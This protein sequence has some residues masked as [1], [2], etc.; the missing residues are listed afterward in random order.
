MSQVDALRM[1]DHVR[2]RLV[3]LAVSE[4]YF[5]DAQ[6]SEVAR[7]LWS[8]PGTEGGLVSELWVEGAF[9]GQRSTDSLKSLNKEGLLP[10]GLY[11]QIAK[12]RVFPV[13]RELYTH[14]LEAFRTAGTS[15]KI[16]PSIVITAGTGLGKTEAF[17]L[18]MLTDLWRAGERLPDGGMRCLIIYPM[19]ALVA[20]QVERI[21]KWLNGQSQ[22]SVFHFTSETPEDARAANRRGE[23]FWANCRMRTR[24]EARGY[25]AHDGQAIE[26]EP[27]GA[28][29]DIVITNYSM[30]EYMLCR[31]QDSR[32][33]GPDLRC[34]IVDEAH[35]YSGVL[36]TEIMMLLRR[37]RERCGVSSEH[38]LHIATSATLGGD[39]ST[40]RTFA[41]DL[42]STSTKNTTVLRGRYAENDFASPESPPAQP[43][44]ASELG[45]FADLELRT[46][47]EEGEII[48]EGEKT[49]VNLSDI[50]S[51]LVSEDVADKS[52]ADFRNCPARFL[53][54]SLHQAPLIRKM[55]NILSDRK[56]NVLCLEEL[57]RLL[58]DGQCGIDERKAT[59]ALLRLSASARFR[60]TDLP[61]VPH[62][63]HFLVRA[64]EGAS[65]CLNSR[66][67]GP[68]DYRLSAIGCLQPYGDRCIYCQ[69]V[70][71]PVHR[72][73][74]CGDWALAAHE[75]Q[76]LCVLEPGYFAA[77]PAHR[78]YYLL[79]KP[80]E[81]ELQEVTIDSEKGE[82]L[83]YGSDGVT[84]W[85]APRET[86]DSPSQHCPTCRSSWAVPVADE[87]EPEWRHTCRG[88][89]G[90]RPFALSVTAE[91]VL[92]D[93]PPYRGDS[94]NWKPAKG[95]RL[96]CFSDSRAAAA[97]LGP[98][99]TQQHEVQVVRAAMAR[100][101]TD[102][103]PAD[104]AD[105]FAREVERL[106]SE[107][108]RNTLTPALRDQLQNELMEKRE[109]LERSKAGTPF[110]QFA[111]LVA[112]R[113]EM[114]ELLERR[115]AEK[116]TASSFG[117][118][119][120]RRNRDAVRM[121]AEAL[122]AKELCR[123]LK[124]Q[125][126][127]E[128]VGLVE[129]AY[130]GIHAL[131]LP[132]LF[133]EKLTPHLRTILRRNWA[134]IVTLL[135]DTVR[136]DGCIDWS[137][138][139][140]GRTWLDESPLH[141]RWLT[142][143][144]GGWASR[145]FVGATISQLRRAFLRNV[146]LSVGSAQA[147]AE[148]LSESALEAIFDQLYA[149]AGNPQFSWLRREEYHQIGP[150][151]ADK[152]I[153][154]LFD[155]LTVRVPTR[156]FRCDATGTIWTNSAV[157]WA[158]IEG[159]RGTLQG[160]DKE[161]LD[162]DPRWGRP[163]RELIDSPILSMGLWAEEHS[164]QLSPQENRRLQDLFKT[165]IRN[166]LSSTTTMELG[167]D[168]GG[169][170]GVLL[171]NVPPG[172]ANHRQRAGRAG[173]RSD[174]TAVVATFARDSD[175]DR[176]AFLRFGDFL[177]RELRKPKVFLNRS[178]V[179]RRHLH[180]VLL[181]EFLR[182]RQ[183]AATGA[184]HAFGKMGAFC[185]INSIPPRWT[186]QSEP[187]PSW[188]CNG[189]DTADEFAEWLN[190]IKSED[191]G[192]RGRLHELSIMTG[193]GNLESQKEWLEF[194]RQ[195]K[196]GFVKGVDEWKRNI[197]QLR[198]AWNE[199]PP[200]PRSS[201]LREMAKA[202]SVR[203]MISA[204]CDIT[205]IEWLADHRFLPR[206]GFPI[207]LQSLSIRRPAGETRGDHSRTDERYRLER[208]SLLALR[209][210][211]PES[212]VLV[213]GRVATSRG[214]RKHWTDSNLDQ[215]LGL[216]YSALECANEHVYVRQTA[217]EACPTCKGKP[218]AKQSLVFPRF[219][220]TTAGWDDL[221]LGTN[222]ER[223]GEQVVCPISF[224]ER[225][226]GGILDDF[227]QI[228]GLRVSYREEAELLVRNSGRNRCGFAICTRCGFAMSEAE[229]GEG[230]MKLPSTFETHAP[231]FSS[232]ERSFCWSK[233]EQIAPVL[234]NR[235]LAARELTDMLLIEWPA[236]T[237]YEHDS[238][239]SL[240]RALALAGTRL[241]ELDERELG[242]E[243]LPLQDS[244]LGIVI[245]ETSPGGSGHCQELIGLGREWIEVSRDVLYVDTA[246]DARCTKACL[247]CILDFSGQYAARRLN[248]PGALNLLD[249]AVP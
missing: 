215:A 61:L 78:T 154:I 175:Y 112:F 16:R 245:Y 164:A 244:N 240:G 19:N 210:Y 10:D 242:M 236:A 22:L 190:Q 140:E 235:V 195:A 205:V 55:A 211:V 149:S 6:I 131:E 30:L 212:Q 150:E 71:L 83:G 44:A 206:Y 159:C 160:I 132:P 117:Q 227:G 234:R 108:S 218:V 100:C 43:A 133:E 52:R 173:R 194:V 157:G 241:L 207:N 229:H 228:P 97:R 58:F 101:V 231:I 167:I 62:R 27:F 136:A 14:Q 156:L 123:P 192:V 163:R 18:P 82:I 40:L 1:A 128:S 111:R 13:E 95:R 87:Q 102:L 233:G 31:P 182:S 28:P 77:S 39:D 15:Q 120:W 24:Q 197:N 153:Q 54:S 225:G 125:T 36:A 222:L 86:R 99:L 138:D 203:Y 186:R 91:T 224:A 146:F 179:I 23:P 114:T 34:I 57:S 239:Y 148:Q 42:F 53:R 180:A 198:D 74:N 162:G 208:S 109:Q 75:N 134:A 41:S 79:T 35:L 76:E 152:A 68:S 124:R 25:E 168:I 88:L 98:L 200:Q 115:E 135:L 248:R 214:L 92:H 139:T 50:V 196:E 113:D 17:L 171:G 230:R 29:P 243:L 118:T 122:V 33:F 188:L 64:P 84:L 170:N 127:V 47:T 56:G 121:H 81:C 129:I 32:F 12:S 67:C 166:I 220:Y 176:Q 65:V 187:K 70:L 107:L 204:L 90:G 237:R 213:G 69:H 106:N 38:V 51:K 105:Y 158:P 7:R 20:D 80:H 126:S 177:R 142:R 232:D 141:G 209:E 189:I 143:S 93:L 155:S 116:H 165:G 130:P 72:C 9:P 184:M 63:L 103:T 11:D 73:D 191:G 201:V 144:R 178:R 59:V 151:H 2:S 21:Y 94:A 183:P 223:V 4:N 174:G 181:S 137:Q 172:P 46:L 161:V 199:F 202:N 26:R 37:V 66:C 110:V 45:Q 49:V 85:K 193:L 119:D 48:E 217:D 96:L 104:S 247:D 246:H 219:G 216:E 8:G 89:V 238:V 185:G 60:S 3:D 221:P 169:L 147:E 226:E 5:R 249:G 145:A